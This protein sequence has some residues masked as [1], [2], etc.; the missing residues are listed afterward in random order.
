MADDFFSQDSVLSVE[1]ATTSGV[2]DDSVS[3]V[4]AEVVSGDT[5]A[6]PVG[7][8]NTIWEFAPDNDLD[9][10]EFADK[11]FTEITSFIK[12]ASGD[13][14]G[15]AYEFDSME[16]GSLAIELDNADGRFTAGNLVSPYYP[17]ITANRRMRVRG[18]NMA[19][20]NVA[21]G[22][23]YRHDT[24]DWTGPL[25]ATQI[26]NMTTGSH[27]ATLLP[28]GVGTSHIEVTL[29][30][31]ITSGT[32]HMVEA[33]VPVELGA[34]LSYSAYVWKVSGTQPAGCQ[35]RLSAHFFDKTGTELAQ[36]DGN[37]DAYTATP[38]PTDPTR[39]SFSTQPP[40]NTK[41]AKLRLAVITSATTTTPVT[42][43]ITGVQVEVPKTN[44]V[45]L[46]NHT[47]NWHAIGPGTT[48]VDGSEG[49]D[50]TWGVGGVGIYMDQP[51]LTPGEM[52]TVTAEIKKTGAGPFILMTTDQGQSGTLMDSEDTWQQVTLAFRARA[53]KEDIRFMPVY[54]SEFG[55]YELAPVTASQHLFI[56]KLRVVE[57]DYSEALPALTLGTT[58]EHDATDFEMPKPIFDGWTEDFIQSVGDHTSTVTVRVNDR[59]SRVGSIT[60][61]NTLQESLFTDKM[62]LIIP[63]IDDPL[64]S[65][66]SVSQTGLWGQYFTS[67]PLKPTRG[68]IGVS[69]Y[70]LGVQGPTVDTAI[71]FNRASQSQ[72]YSVPVPYSKDYIA[73]G[74][75][76]G[77]TVY[78]KYYYATWS[79]TYR[80]FD[81]DSV[82]DG[83]NMYQGALPQDVSGHHSMCGFN[84]Q[85]LQ[86]DLKDAR[87]H[88]FAFALYS[89]HWWW[90]PGG[91]AF[92]GTHS[93]LQK[94]RWAWDGRARPSRWT[95]GRWGRNVWMW[96]DM[97]VATGNEFKDG[98]STGL[99]IGPHPARDLHYYGIFA[100]A[101]DPWV[102]RPLLY[103]VY[104]K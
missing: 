37:R 56:R 14:R 28:F 90:G 66:G 100:G 84:Y 74:P 71:E 67:L 42:F 22:G 62:D 103:V 7:F 49:V 11:G 21:S 73:S 58:S 33:Y 79:Q 8:P 75:T 70:V 20:M 24:G 18:K 101:F 60:L 95:V 48:V 54:V 19:S 16:A 40:A 81:N 53:V 3:A 77:K 43:A 85:A 12:N 98:R 47:E 94:E 69:N 34:R 59:L 27:V 6:E 80:D 97:G 9:E 99:T 102:H 65:Q 96:Y 30:T 17:Y 93:Y 78:K 55:L 1:G 82:V 63:F 29:K 25:H 13:L 23:G 38:V 39:L 44:M 10:R 2:K 86:A 68:D 36:L 4:D 76:P 51:R 5:G 87:I 52:Y 45:P 83:G 91:W 26:E 89:K 72:G 32:R 57:G 50:H 35:L 31:G 61:S 41:Y 92:I 15:R 64:D 104:E 46:V 88:S